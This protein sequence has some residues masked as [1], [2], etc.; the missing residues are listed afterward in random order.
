M[1]SYAYIDPRSPVLHP[2]HSSPI[3]IP[4]SSPAPPHTSLP[5]P[6]YT[7]RCS[8][9]PSSQVTILL[10]CPRLYSCRWCLKLYA[11]VCGVLFSTLWLVG[12]VYVLSQTED[13]DLRM[14]R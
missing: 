13:K 2:L 9:A 1:I 6:A 14:Q 7:R 4:H 12:H 3:D 5:P 11:M 8:I 10:K